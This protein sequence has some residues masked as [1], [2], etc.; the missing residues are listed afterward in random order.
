M[1]RRRALSAWTPAP[2][3]PRTYWTTRS[4]PLAA[5]NAPSA[6]IA[7]GQRQWF[8]GAMGSGMSGGTNAQ[9]PSS[10]AS[11][12]TTP[13][14]RSPRVVYVRDVARVVDSQWERRSGYHYL[15]HEPGAQSQTVPSIEVS[16]LQN[17][18]ASSSSGRAG[19]H[20]GCAATGRRKPRPALR[21]RV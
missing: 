9:A 3:M 6:G 17:P 19:D 7:V 21:D 15:K 14:A 20:A 18:G 12:G 1:A 4:R 16:V 2:A 10:A 11:A 5:E 8:T 13:P